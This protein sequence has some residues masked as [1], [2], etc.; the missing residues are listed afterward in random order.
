[1]MSSWHHQFAGRYC[2][3][4][5]AFQR[6]A[7]VAERAGR[8]SMVREDDG[9]RPQA[10]YYLG[11]VTEALAELEQIVIRE[12]RTGPSGDL[13]SAMEY[14]ARQYAE[15]GQVERGLALASEGLDEGLAVGFP[16]HAGACGDASMEALIW[17]GRLDDA[18]ERLEVVRDLDLDHIWGGASTCDLVLARGDVEAAAPLVHEAGRFGLADDRIPDDRWAL[19]QTRLAGLRDDAPAALAGATSYLAR[20]GGCD[21]P[22]IAGVAARVGFQALAL[23]GPTP[24]PQVDELLE[25]AATQRDRA[26]AG[27]TD[28]WRGGYYGVQLALGEAYAARVEGRPAVEEFRAAVELADPFGAFFALEPRLELA[29]ELLVHGGRDEGRELLVECWTAAHGMGAHGVE[30]QAARLA[31]R[32]RVPL[33]ESAA[34]EGPLSRLTPRERE[35]LGQLAKG[36]TNKAI[37]SELFISEKTVSVHVSNLLAKLGVENRGAAAALARD[38]VGS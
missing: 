15:A 7:E 27:L 38:L 32:H 9:L 1:M 36:A 20:L 10:L 28:E 37:A 34:S 8:P 3:G 26:R 2:V 30:R 11:R 18:E 5:E 25:M 14:L 13:F 22:L 6:A 12:R 35:V 17:S 19:R 4:L 24:G 33:P 31:T 16:S 23:A 29:Q 21:S